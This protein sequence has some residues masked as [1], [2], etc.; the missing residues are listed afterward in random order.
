MIVQ[1]YFRNI[2]RMINFFIA[3]QILDLTISINFNCRIT[4]SFNTVFMLYIQ[5][6]FQIGQ[7]NMLKLMSVYMYVNVDKNHYFGNFSLN[8]QYWENRGRFNESSYH[9]S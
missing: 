8:Y 5:I 1:T 7:K 3:F 2:C 6:K 4:S 9:L